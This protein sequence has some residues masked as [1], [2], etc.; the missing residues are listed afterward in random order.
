MNPRFIAFLSH[1]AV[2]RKVTASTQNQA[3]SALLFLYKD[4]LQKPLEW[5]SNIQ[6]AKKAIQAA[7]RV[8]QGSAHAIL[9]NLEGTK[10]LMAGLLYGAGLRITECLRL[11]VKD[12]DFGYDQIV[13]RDGKDQKDRSDSL[14]IFNE[15]GIE[16]TS[17]LWLS[18][19][20]M[21]GMGEYPCADNGLLLNHWYRTSR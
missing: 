17:Y 3:L 6:R 9:R 11:R 13:V 8:Y 14:A 15:G 21:C 4:V 16:D 20:S 1:L 19:H 18:C 5:M 2:T 12:I 7:S 10:A